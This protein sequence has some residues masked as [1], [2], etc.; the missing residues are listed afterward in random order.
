MPVHLGRPDFALARGWM[1]GFPKKLGEVWMTRNFGLGGPADPGLR[2]G[3]RH[4]GTCTAYG[5]QVMAATVTLERESPDGLAAQ[6]AADRERA[7]LPAAGRGP[8]R[9]ARRARARP[10]GL[11]RPQLLPAWEGEATLELSGGPGLEHDLLAPVRV[12]R[13]YR[14]S[15]GYT[16]DDLETVIDYTDAR[17]A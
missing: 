9:R 5:R 1:Q 10:L 6:R 15:F 2:P 3:A 13:G 12:G 14:Y 16:V 7:P 8:P 4:G 11:P 17:A